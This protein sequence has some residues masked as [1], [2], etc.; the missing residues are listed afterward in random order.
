MHIFISF[1]PAFRSKRIMIPLVV[2][3]TMESS[4]RMIRFPFTFMTIGFSF[5][6]TARS[7]CFCPGWIKVRPMY[8]FFKSPST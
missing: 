6:R 8:L 7:L 1:A 3:R 5:I 2:P 4:T